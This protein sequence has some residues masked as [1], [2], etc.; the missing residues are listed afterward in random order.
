MRKTKSFYKIFEDRFRGSRELITERLK[1][2]LPL[3]EPIK[4]IYP[5]C[6]AIDLGCGRGE[7]L[8]LLNANG[9]QSHGVDIDEGMLENAKEFGLSTELMDALEYLTSLPDDSISVVTGFHIAEHLPFEILQELIKESLR[10]LKPAGLLILE[11]PNPENITV[12]SNTFYIDPTHIRPLPPLLLSFL[13]EFYGFVRVTVFRLNSSLNESSNVSLLNVING[14]SPDY[15]VIAQKK[16][17]LELLELFDDEFYKKHGFALDELATKYEQTSSARQELVTLLH[18]QVQR[19]QEFAAQLLA[20]QQQANQEKAEQAR[21]HDAQ[22]HALHGQHAKR[23]KALTQQLQAKQQELHN[24]QKD[25]VKRERE[26]TVQ[27]LAIQQQANQEKAEQERNHNEQERALLRQHTEREQSLIQQL[28]N[29]QEELLRVEQERKKHEQILSEQTSQVRQELE[30]LLRTLAQREQAVAEQMLN[31]QQQAAQE[32]A[33][34]AHRHSEQERAVQREHAEREQALTQQMEAAQQELRRLEQEWEQNKKVLGKEI[35]ALQNKAQT[36]HHAQQSQAQQHNAEL[37]TKLEEQNHLIETWAALEAQL[38]A[39]I[40]TEQQIS[41]HLRQSLAHVQQSLATT[42]ASLTWRMTA[43][44]RTLVSVIVP[45]KK[46]DPASP[47]MRETELPHAIMPPI[48]ES[49]PIY[50]QHPTIESIM[51]HSAQATNSP[52]PTLA[53]TLDELLAYHDQQF[54][55][56][57]FHTLLGRD[58]DPEGLGYYLGRVRRGFSKM[59]LVAQLRLSK[60]G[61]AHAKERK[62]LGASLSGLDKAIKRYQRGQY[63]L[64]GWLFRRLD[65]GEGN[66]PNERKLRSIGNQLFL[67]SDDSNRRFNQLEAALAG[68]HHLVEQQTA[69]L[70]HLLKQQTQT[71]VSTQESISMTTPD[72]SSISPIQPPE[73][74]GLKQL[75]PHARD[76]YFQLKTA[77][78]IHA[79]RAA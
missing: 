5:D 19:E 36:L 38:K 67:L 28:K 27:V 44:L 1:V 42:R 70:H 23:E 78:A 22:A 47:M 24:L 57:A 13:P 20:I 18:T 48:S 7:W 29:G 37:S 21:S 12:G 61:R 65:E 74:D 6:R 49:Q 10:V 73:P 59:R 43:P 14:A 2:Y 11:T 66:H 69:G 77:A 25:R 75:S 51:P 56:C 46:P 34:L 53:S 8:E 4:N 76:I 30:N 32:I 9:F 41:L 3:I 50:V 40:I 33:E 64:I 15:S 58:P 68:L 63:P 79:G 55:H 71:V 45:K 16:A 39:E 52:P 54:V 26:V 35:A 60:E 31:L 72:T 17:D 62:A